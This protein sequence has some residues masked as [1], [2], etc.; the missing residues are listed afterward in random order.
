[1]QLLKYHLEILLIA[2]IF[3]FVLLQN[4]GPHMKIKVGHGRCGF[5]LQYLYLKDSLEHNLILGGKK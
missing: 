5:I 4:P 3:N 2:I 1:M